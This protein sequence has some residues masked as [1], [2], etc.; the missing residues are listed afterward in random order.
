MDY[1]F[2][3]ETLDVRP[4]AVVLSVAF[5]PFYFGA[6]DSFR[7]L[8][9]RAVH[10]R[11]DITEQQRRGRT[12]ETST[13]RF[14]AKQPQPVLERQ[15]AVL[16]EPNAGPDIYDLVSPLRMT[17]LF[18]GE[19]E[20]ARFWCRGAHFDAALIDSLCSAFDVPSPWHFR[21]VRDIRTLEEALALPRATEEE[22]PG[23]VAHDPCHDA[24]REAYVLQRAAVPPMEVRSA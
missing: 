4:T 1:A 2:D 5:V 23:F 14:W 9:S 3:C 22:T 20:P 15:V 13:L 16:D 8:L 17:N 6:E 19:K 24:A 21:A 11:F 10:F 12:V 7:A 18:R